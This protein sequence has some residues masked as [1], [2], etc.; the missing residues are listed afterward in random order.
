MAFEA[1]R[2]FLARA[3]AVQPGFAVTE[4]NAA[5]VAATV[6]AWM[7]SRWP[8]SWPP[9]GWATCPWRR[10]WSGSW[11]RPAARSACEC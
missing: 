6:R 10:C 3:A 2:L 9:R 5:T 1:I 8:S 4:A 11:E 7:A